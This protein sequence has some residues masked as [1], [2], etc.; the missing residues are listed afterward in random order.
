MFGEIELI[1][2]QGMIRDEPINWNIRN[3]TGVGGTESKVKN[4]SLKVVWCVHMT[5][6]YSEI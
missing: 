4:L 3:D 5:L 2:Y 1:I 6:D